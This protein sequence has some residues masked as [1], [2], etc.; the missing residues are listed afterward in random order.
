MAAKQM[1]LPLR[2]ILCRG[3]TLAWGPAVL[4]LYAK[5]QLLHE[6]LIPDSLLPP[7]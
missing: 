3:S 4:R 7:T 2:E 1:P 6:E 5:Q